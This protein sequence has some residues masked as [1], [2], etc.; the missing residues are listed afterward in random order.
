VSGDGNP[1][2]VTAASDA[3]KVSALLGNGDGSFRR[4][5]YFVLEPF[6][7]AV[8]DV[9][10]DGRP[11]LIAVREG[12]RDAVVVV[13][14]NDG[15]GRFRRARRSPLKG[16]MLAAGDFNGDGISDVVEEGA[17]DFVLRLATGDGRLAAPRTVHGSGGADITV[18]DF[19]GDGKLDVALA[20]LFSHSVRVRL[21][22]GDGTFG[23]AREFGV[24]RDDATRVTTADLN[25]DAKL[26]L[27]VTR[28]FARVGVLLGRGDGTFDAQR[29]YRTGREAGEALVGDFNLDGVADIAASG[30]LANPSAVL[31]GVGDGAFQPR[32]TLPP[33]FTFTRA[34]W[35]Y[36]QDESIQA[37]GAVEDFNQDGRADI[38]F[39]AYDGHQIDGAEF[40][41][42]PLP[43]WTT[44]LLNWTN[45]P[46]PPCVVV[47]VTGEP[48]RLAKRH[49]VH[50]GCGVGHVRYRQTRKK[51]RDRVMSQ[52][53]TAGA[54]LTNRA[55]VKLVVARAQGR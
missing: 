18:G 52:Q 32:R 41:D 25:N 6:D 33:F 11:D 49:L 20:A 54:V 26:D 36:G 31:L 4:H 23:P 37:E 14:V 51:R 40:F 43:A 10:G 44:V 45:L 7:V 38:A 16:A 50:A 12:A 17:G 5:D 28:D 48:L 30:S 47:P 1:D 8:G 35:E 21:G 42:L 2:L 55:P 53:P 19:N 39:P 24:A 3:N 34:V 15:A 27:V 46:A 13:F 22:L 29:N 9:S